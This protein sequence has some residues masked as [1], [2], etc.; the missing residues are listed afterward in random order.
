MCEKHAAADA[1]R[2][3]NRSHATIRAWCHAITV[4]VSHRESADYTSQTQEANAYLL[5]GATPSASQ[6]T[7]YLLRNEAIKQVGEVRDE[8]R[9]QQGLTSDARET[10]VAQEALAAA[11]KAFDDYLKLAPPDQLATARSALDLN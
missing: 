3:P 11:L 5:G 8:I 1:A 9:Y 10:E 4:G 7:Q 2:V 6:T